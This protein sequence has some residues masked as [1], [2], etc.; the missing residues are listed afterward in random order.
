MRRLC[1]LS[2]IA[3]LASDLPQNEMTAPI[4][5]FV[6]NRPGHCR[7]TLEHLLVNPLA[8]VSD[9][10]VFSDGPRGEADA[11][12]VAE[13]RDQVRHI[14]GFRSVT[15]IERERNLGLANSITDGVGRL[16]SEHG[17]VIVLEDDLLVSPDFLDLMNAS[18]ER[19]AESEQVMQVSGYMYPGDYGGDTDTL[20]LP[21]VS[22]WG[23]GTWNRAWVKYDPGMSGYDRLM[24]DSNLKAQFNLHGAY[25]YLKMLEQQRR[26]EIDSWGIR[27]HLSVFMLDGLVLYPAES[28][29]INI[30]IDGSGT[31]GAGTAELQKLKF[32]G[33]MEHVKLRY[34]DTI[35]MD[36]NAMRNLQISLRAAR[37]GLVK[38]AM[39]KLF[40]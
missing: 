26:G 3:R 31:H 9:L 6:Y 1:I 17:R 29:V 32:E 25:D 7:R 14:A 12:A 8:K 28:R 18:L 34:P 23:W 37:P 10:F 24:S 33:G 20:F 11:L 5:L 30:G 19:Y 13:V 4:A 35:A 39:R 36:E 40:G 22:C 16:C 2:K 38:R 15:V 21:M 27:W